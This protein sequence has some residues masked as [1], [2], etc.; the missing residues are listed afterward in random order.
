[1]AAAWPAHGALRVSPGI[2]SLAVV[3]A[4]V[5]VSTG[6]RPSEEA[7]RPAGWM[8]AVT[9][10]LAPGPVFA[11]EVGPLEIPGPQA[12]PVAMRPRPSEVPAEIPA[13]VRRS[14]MAPAQ[15]RQA[16]LARSPSTEAVQNADPAA[17]IDWLL[18]GGRGRRQT[19]G[20]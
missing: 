15:R 4:V 7:R 10:T 2:A 14:E 13:P 17:A 16:T 3:V 12:R 6:E 9:G 5:L 1:M 18:Q 20:P 19:E 8:P 11:P